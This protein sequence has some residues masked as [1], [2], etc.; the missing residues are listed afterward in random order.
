M[1]ARPGPSLPYRLAL[2][3]IGGLQGRC[4]L[5]IEL[6]RRCVALSKQRHKDGVSSRALFENDR[7]T[8]GHT[9]EGFMWDGQ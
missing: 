5:A 6:H 9:P 1:G 8:D 7:G 3:A 2:A 4:L